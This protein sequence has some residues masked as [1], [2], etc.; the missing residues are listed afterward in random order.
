MGLIRTALSAAAGIA[1]AGSVKGYLSILAALVLLVLFFAS[2]K[3]VQKKTGSGALPALTYSCVRSLVGAVILFLAYCLIY[4]RLPTVTGY[5]LL[6]ASTLAVFACTYTLI[7]F[8][9]MK[10]GS[11][12]VYMVFLMLGGMIIPYLYGV[13]F[14]KEALTPCRIIGVVLIMISLLFPLAD[15]RQPVGETKGG[16]GGKVIFAVLCFAVFLLNG[17]VCIITKTHASGIL[18]YP[19]SDDPTF[20]ILCAAACCI[21]SGIELLVLLALQKLKKQPENGGADDS[22]EPF[23]VGAAVRAA[24]L[25][26]VLAAIFDGGSFFLQ[27]VGAKE[28]PASVMFPIMTGGSVVLTALA[29]FL[30]FKERP[31]KMELIGLILTFASTFLFLF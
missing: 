28:L 12:S 24:M 27:Q 16:R 8:R 4:R 13:I 3:S 7:G 25:F 11:L 26:I 19:T 22:P 18:G 5:S 23:R 6:L 29:G 10:Y 17:M 30:L 15:K 9:I 14:L 2:G 1:G 21:I 31:G 20:V